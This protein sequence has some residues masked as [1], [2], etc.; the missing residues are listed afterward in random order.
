VARCGKLGARRFVAGDQFPRIADITAVRCDCFGRVSKI[1]IKPDQTISRGGTRKSRLAASTSVT[2]STL[3]FRFRP[4]SRESAP[5]LPLS[6][7]PVLLA[8]H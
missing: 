3:R 7:A 8:A 5:Y 4:L 1:A 2:T 6:P